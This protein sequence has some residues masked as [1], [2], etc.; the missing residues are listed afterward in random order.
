MIIFFNSCKFKIEFEIN[1]ILD[2]D[3]HYI[4][5]VK[6]EKNT[7]ILSFVIKNHELMGYK[8]CCIKQMD[9]LILFDRCNI[10]YKIYIK[11]MLMIERRINIIIA[12][13]AHLINKLDRTK[14]HPL[15]RKYSHIFFNN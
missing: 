4:H 14:N 6:N 11:T 2:I 13:N 3:T 10:T 9:F 15:K 12:K 7:S 5:N 1:F 8:Y